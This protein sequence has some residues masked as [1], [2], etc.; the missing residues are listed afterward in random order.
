MKSS[1]GSLARLN[2]QVALPVGMCKG[3]LLE[4]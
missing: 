2:P 3:F 4:L 1:V